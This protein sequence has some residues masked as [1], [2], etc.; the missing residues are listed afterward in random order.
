MQTAVTQLYATGIMAALAAAFVWSLNFVVPFVIGHY[1][2]FGFA[3]VR[4]VVSGAIGAITLTFQHDA[5]RDLTLHSPAFPGRAR[6][7][8]DQQERADRR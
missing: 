3:L 1:T 4:F 8:L 2:V 6:P 5:M 7:R